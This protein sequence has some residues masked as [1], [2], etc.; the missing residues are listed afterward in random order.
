[1]KT[2]RPGTVLI[3]ATLLYRETNPHSMD[4]YGKEQ[5][6]HPGK[7]QRSNNNNGVEFPALALPTGHGILQ[8]A[9]W[10]PYNDNGGTAAAVAGKG[11]V[12]VGADTRLNDNFNFL[13]RSDESKLCKLTPTTILASGGMQADRLELQKVLETRIRW[14]EFTNGGRLP[15]TSALAQLL[16]SVLYSRRQFPYYTFNIIAG[17][18]DNGNGVCYSYDAVGCTEPLNYGTTGTGSSFI[19]PLMDC[20]IRKSNQHRAGHVIAPPDMT[21]DEAL[22]MLKNAFTSAAERDIFTGDAARF[23]VLTPEGC[24]EETLQ[25]RK[26]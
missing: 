20:L 2:T 24:S 13:T 1:M 15:K 22:Q 18:D 26:D 9:E 19:E 21:V 17:L 7:S 23:Y 12:I 11:F 4:Y 6:A 16:S 8:H 14:Y 10:S 25:L 3:S 5:K